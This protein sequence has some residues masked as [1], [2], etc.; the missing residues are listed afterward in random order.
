MMHI[1]RVIELCRSLKQALAGDDDAAVRHAHEAL[2]EPLRPATVHY[3]TEPDTLESVAHPMRDLI[4]QLANAVWECINPTFGTH[5]LKLQRAVDEVLQA[6]DGDEESSGMTWQDAADRMKRLRGQGYPWT[7]QPRMAK[8]FHCSSFT[9][10][11][12][13]RNTPELH[14]WTKHQPATSP[15][16]RPV[17]DG[18]AKSTETDPAD[19]AAIREYL[20]SDLSL[21]ER[22]FFN[23]LSTEDKIWFLKK[24]T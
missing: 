13:I 19:E 16:A 2:L 1:D 21:E 20:E 14:A 10:N 5:R 15:R 9:I 7:S 4:F 8:R 3:A 18:T 17:S 24:T 12:A 6:A 22:A 11:K 23:G